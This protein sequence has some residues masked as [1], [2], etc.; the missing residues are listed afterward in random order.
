MGSRHD[1]RQHGQSRPHA[2]AIICRKRQP[3][4]Y[5]GGSRRIGVKMNTGT[6]ATADRRRPSDLAPPFKAEFDL[7]CTE[8]QYNPYSKVHKNHLLPKGGIEKPGPNIPAFPFAAHV[9]PPG[10]P[11]LQS[12]VDIRAAEAS[13]VHTVQFGRERSRGISTGSTPPSIER[14]A[15]LASTFTSSEFTR[16]NWPQAA[17]MSRPRGLRRKQGID[18]RTIS[19]KAAT[20]SGDGRFEGNTRARIQRNQVHFRVQ[21]RQQPHHA[22]RVGGR[23]IH[24]AQQH[25]FKRQLLPRRA[26]DSAG[27]RPASP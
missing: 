12:P 9:P 8:L 20:R 3:E 16:F 10:N 15:D 25:V 18:A 19:W 11:L 7:D 5:S 4:K 14:L 27:R 26:A 6:A 13:P 1:R 2:S 24:S 23:V 22:A 21:V 17:K